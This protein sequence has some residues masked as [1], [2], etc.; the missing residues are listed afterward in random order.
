MLIRISRCLISGIQFRSYCFSNES[1]DW[2][3]NAFI[4]TILVFINLFASLIC[5]FLIEL[6][7]QIV[8]VLGYL[9]IAIDLLD[10]HDEV[11][12]IFAWL[13]HLHGTAGGV[14]LARWIRLSLLMNERA[15]I[16]G[17]CLARFIIRPIK[18][19]ATLVD[20][21]TAA[22]IELLAELLFADSINNHIIWS[23]RFELMSTLNILCL[24]NHKWAELRHQIEFLA[25]RLLLGGRLGHLRRSIQR[26]RAIYVK[27]QTAMVSPN[28]CK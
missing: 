17:G 9:L 4:F 24:F 28:G 19:F 22:L 1:F 26:W 2:S 21:N 13:V 5:R 8:C 3:S 14:Y 11:L 10:Y 20:Q 6:F 18:V 23:M 12:R 16:G 25:N 15:S 27:L 7:W